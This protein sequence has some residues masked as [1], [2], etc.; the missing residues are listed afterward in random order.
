MKSIK[1]IK[2]ELNK[3][4]KLINTISIKYEYRAN[5]HIIEI[6]PINIFQSKSYINKEIELEN[7]FYNLFPN[8]DILF[9][10]ENSLTE[11]KNPLIELL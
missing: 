9:I 8:E 4:H 5:T 2:S 10:T 6:S 11:I 3:I 7:N 1:Y